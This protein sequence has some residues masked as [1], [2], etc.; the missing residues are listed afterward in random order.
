MSKVVSAN[1]KCLRE[2]V[3]RV[4]AGSRRATF[5]SELKSRVC[6][7]IHGVQSVGW[8]AKA[9]GLSSSLVK[10]WSESFRMGEARVQVIKVKRD[11]SFCVGFFIGDFSFQLSIFMR[12]RDAS[13]PY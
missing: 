10:S 1:L 2:E 12:R 13:L 11:R 5:S 8:V 4:R 9:C 6:A 3:C 7:E